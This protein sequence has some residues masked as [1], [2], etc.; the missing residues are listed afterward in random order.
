MI[1]TVWG[2]DVRPAP[3]DVVS[4]RVY[5]CVPSASKLAVDDCVISPVNLLMTKLPASLPLTIV[6][7][8][9]VP[10]SSSVAATNPTLRPAVFTFSVTEKL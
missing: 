4:V 3:S 7:F 9:G 8:C 5:D 10:P 6:Q 1:V 2:A